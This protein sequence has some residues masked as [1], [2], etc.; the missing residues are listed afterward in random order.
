MLTVALG[1]GNA[2]RQPSLNMHQ[3]ECRLSFGT[4]AQLDN[5]SNYTSR[6]DKLKCL[7]VH[8]VYAITPLKHATQ[9]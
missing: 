5:Q 2:D 1:A 4:C 3:R 6:I 9:T 8:I 7:N